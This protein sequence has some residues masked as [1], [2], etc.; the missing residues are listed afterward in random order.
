V[1]ADTP[2][3]DRYT[4]Y[5]QQK[6]DAIRAFYDRE[7]HLYSQKWLKKNSYYYDQIKR[8]LT[9]IIPP[10]MRVLDAGC[11]C[12]HLLDHLKPSHG[13]G[14]DFSAS[15]I[16][17][18]RRQYPHLQF[19]HMDFEETGALNETFDFVIS[20]AS[21]T[22]MTDIRRCL[23][24]MYTFM[25]PETRLIIVSYNYLWQPFIKLG[26]HAGLRPKSPTENWFSP[27]DYKNILQTT[28]FEVV[29]EGYRTIVPKKIPLAGA[30][31]NNF[32]VRLPFF[33][34]LGVTYYIIARP[35]IP[36]QQ[37]EKM[38][39]SIVVPCKNEED[40]INDLVS[41][42][43]RIGEDTEII[44]VDDKSTDSTAKKIQ[45]QISSCPEK[46][47]KLI[48]GPGIG[49]GAACRAGFAAANNDIF[50]ILDADMTVMPEVLPEFFELITQGKGEFING[51]RLLYPMENQA[52][53]LANIFGN[54]MFAMLFTFLLEQPIKDTLCG[55]KVIFK[56]DY[57]KILASRD[58]FGNIDRWGDYDWIFGAAR[59]NLKIIE[60]P[61]HYVSRTAGQTKMTGRLR[62][63]L[64]MLRM[65]WVAFIKLK[66]K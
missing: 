1:T 8:L 35:L 30:L 53:R 10:G 43:P 22:E 44:F 41:R 58:Y 25:E 50:M 32:F 14:I 39:V 49:K 7:A 5:L 24:S 26:A 40:N 13:L 37:P 60:L 55:T 29:R 33:N 61:V 34:R 19:L 20:V 31:F 4:A 64:I 51:S 56:R 38:T 11:G 6:K 48:H 47:I 57:P 18:A 36:F 59:N 62:N 66:L 28:N 65:C 9:S 46:K 52:M 23:K 2:S 63:A 45:Q 27:Q 3:H 54:K 15:M 42:I 21:I 17:E 12:G 16:A